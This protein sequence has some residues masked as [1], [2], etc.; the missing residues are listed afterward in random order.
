MTTTAKSTWK[1]RRKSEP[2]RV[3]NAKPNPKSRT[4]VVDRT[5][6]KEPNLL[7]R[8]GE[9]LTSPG[10]PL[11]NLTTVKLSQIRR[12]DGSGRKRVNSMLCKVHPEL[13]IPPFT[14]PTRN[15]P[16]L[17]HFRRLGVLCWFWSWVVKGSS[18][19]GSSDLV[20]WCARSRLI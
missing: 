15:V 8:A 9:A 13:Y 5:P 12:P 7:K 4:L 1:R 20:V 3:L 10:S 18:L 19:V 2:K 6:A 11:A 17:Y 14:Q 16:D